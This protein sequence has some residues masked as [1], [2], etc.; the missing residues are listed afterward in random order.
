M[1][2]DLRNAC[3]STCGGKAGTLGRLIRDGFPVPDGFVLPF[4][5]DASDGS[6]P[7]DRVAQV[8]DTTPLIGVPGSRGVA[9]GPA[10]TVAGPADFGRV[11]PGDILPP[12][13]RWTGFPGGLRA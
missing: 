10:R 9:S 8:C 3:P 11:R 13:L 4:E 7:P 2:V 5:A 12:E 1:V 6:A